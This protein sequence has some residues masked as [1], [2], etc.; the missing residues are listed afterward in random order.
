MPS[1][2]MC[3]FVSPVAKENRHFNALR[4][5]PD[6]VHMYLY[7]GTRLYIF[8]VASLEVKFHLVLFCFFIVKNQ[9]EFS[10]RCIPV[11]ILSKYSNF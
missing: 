1:Y 5:T 2:Y 11:Y 8:D 4:F 9:S 10:A 3:M 7:Y 6:G